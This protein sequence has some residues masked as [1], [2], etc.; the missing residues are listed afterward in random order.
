[1]ASRQAVGV[2]LMKLKENDKVVAATCI[3]LLFYLK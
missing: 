2:R 3:W 1:V